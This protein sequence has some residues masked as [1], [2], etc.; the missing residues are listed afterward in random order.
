MILYA[1]LIVIAFTFGLVAITRVSPTLDSRLQPV[2]RWSKKASL[3]S[4]TFIVATVVFGL[5]L[6]SLEFPPGSIALAAIIS[7]VVVVKRTW[8][9]V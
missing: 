6:D 8:H 4:A 2:L 3:V 5:M 9:R 7:T 1:M